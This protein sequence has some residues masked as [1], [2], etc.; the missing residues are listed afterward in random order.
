MRLINTETMMLAEFMGQVQKYAILSHTW[1]E[2]EVSFQDFTHPNKE[3]RLRKQG[4]RKIEK[5]CELAREA[6][7]LYV[8]VDTCCIDKTSSAELAEA[9]NS[10]FQWY[11]D[12]AVCY[13]WLADLLPPGRFSVKDTNSRF[14]DCRWFTRGWTLQELIAPKEVKFYDQ[15]WTFC[16]T[17]IDLSR[18]ISAIT[19]IDVQVLR[20]ADLLY[21]LPIAQRMSWAANRQTTRVEDIAY[22]LLGI[23]DVNMPLLYGEGPKAFT[24]LQEEIARESN[25]LSLFAWKAKSV[26]QTHRGILASTPSEFHDSGSIGVTQRTN[27]N[28]DFLMTNKGLRLDSDLYPG[29]NGSYLMPL[30]CTCHDEN[31]NAQ[32]IGILLK[33][34]GGGVYSRVKSDEFGVMDSGDIQPFK[35][36]N[37]I[38]ISKSISSALSVT[39]DRSHRDAFFF[40][41]GFNERGASVQAQ[42]VSFEALEIE[43]NASWDSQRRMI[44]TYGSSSFTAYAFFYNLSR[45]STFTV[46]FGKTDSSVEPW[47]TVFGIGDMPQMPM[48]DLK[49]LEALGSKRKERYVMVKGIRVDAS[50]ERVAVEGEEVYCIDISYS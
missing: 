42:N 18:T 44:L 9:I 1:G 5:V 32:N 46:A 45:T 6:G 30:N 28:P 10:M 43:P 50:L 20:N 13:A 16:G 3:V 19:K 48:R 14:K 31:G 36:S 34:S 7:L 22:S 41:R 38:F 29:Q 37:G 35:K 8:W 4:F 15:Q 39:L 21:Y 33:M 26:D 27:F 25:D 24:R 12:A 47:L 2:E 49:K 40:R 11:K 23:F 17:K